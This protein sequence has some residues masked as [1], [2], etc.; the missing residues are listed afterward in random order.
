M[1][2]KLGRKHRGDC[3]SKIAKIVPIGNPRWPPWPT[4]FFIYT[5]IPLKIFLSE[6]RRPLPLIFGDIASFSSHAY[7]T[8]RHPAIMLLSSTPSLSSENLH[9]QQILNIHSPMKRVHSLLEYTRD[10]DTQVSELGPSGPSC[11]LISVK[12]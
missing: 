10:N 1:D 9:F 6:T 12:V 8:I 2:F 4:S 11:F 3:R 7:S 5:Y